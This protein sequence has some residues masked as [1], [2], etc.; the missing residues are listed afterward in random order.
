[1]L[2]GL[3]G[4]GVLHWWMARS[5]GS[6]MLRSRS[7]SD[8]A[9]QFLIQNMP[10]SAY[11]RATQALALDPANAS[12]RINLAQALRL[13]GEAT[14]AAALLSSLA[15]DATAQRGAR[16]EAWETLGSIALDDQ[17]WGEAV[18]DFGNSF[19]MDSSERA[20]SQLGYALSRASQPLQALALLRRGLVLYPGSAAL[21]KNAGLA[22]MELDSLRSARLE[23]ERAL[24]LMPDFGPALG[25]HARLEARA[26]N[27]RE[28]A[29]DWRAFLATHPGADDSAEVGTDLRRLLGPL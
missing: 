9:A 27:T 23:T 28:A 7:L 12:A 5:F 11:V 6:R 22:L 26:G 20:F 13:R 21:H 8:A 18:R 19:A 2:A 10:D 4:Y 25:L 16:A 15:H 24:E 3:L 17:T 1:M 14:R 29:Q